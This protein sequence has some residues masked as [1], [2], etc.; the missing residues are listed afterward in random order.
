M[1]DGVRVALSPRLCLPST[2]HLLPS[3]HAPSSPLGLCLL[4]EHWKLPGAYPANAARIPR[5][6]ANRV[7]G[8]AAPKPGQ[9]SP[10]RQRGFLSAAS[11]V[12]QGAG[13][14]LPGRA[15]ACL[16]Q[17]CLPKQTAW[18]ALQIAGELANWEAEQ[19]GEKT[20]AGGTKGS[21]EDGWRG[22]DTP[23]AR[24]PST[25]CYSWSHRLCQQHFLH[26]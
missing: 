7:K 1:R 14:V 3:P 20:D 5:S 21:K 2:S 8:R 13:R 15:A 25:D 16:E 9:E 11:A 24:L 4:L 10:E 17:Q 18:R 6:Q 19:R 22:L 26:V 12:L 23:R